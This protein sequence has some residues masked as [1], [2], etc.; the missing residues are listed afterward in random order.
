M[1]KILLL[2]IENVHQTENELFAL[3]EIYQCIYVVYAKSPITISLDGLNLLA[4]FIVN[5]RIILIK[6]PKVGK[7]AADFGLAFIAGQLSIQKNMED[8]Q[9]DVISK[10]KKIEYIV[11]LF[12]LMGRKACLIKHESDIQ[13]HNDIED[14]SSIGNKSKI[15]EILITQA[16]SDSNKIKIPSLNHI[17]TKPHLQ[18]VKDYCDF[19]QKIS[20]NRPKKVVGLLNSIQSF[21]KLEHALSAQQFFS[22]LEKQNIINQDDMKVVYNEQLIL[23]WSNLSNANQISDISRL[24]NQIETKIVS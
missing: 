1:K 13:F 22:F 4:E 23:A 16:H 21:F 3:L 2:D 15:I 6:M 7:D 18:L 10:D 19:L 11:D 17:R 5:K 24:I 9:F 8:V 14:V 20:N 12:V